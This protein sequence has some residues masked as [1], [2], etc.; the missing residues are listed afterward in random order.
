M[1]EGVIADFSAALVD[2]YDILVSSLPPFF[3]NFVNF[4]VIVFFIFIYSVFVWKF[5]KFISH[6]NIFGLNLN[7]YN[8]TEDPTTNKL[9]GGLFYFLEYLI[10]LPFAIFVW[11]FGVTIFLVVMGKSLD[12]NTALIISAAVVAAIRMTSY[13]NG[14]LSKELAKLLPLNLLA[15][16]LIESGFFDA[17]RILG[18]IAQI[19]GLLSNVTTYLI[20]IIIL[21]AVLR[22]FDFTFS[23]FGLEEEQ[24]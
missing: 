2:S 1:A 16:S 4:F 13:Y 20:F 18:Q 7:K 15:L 5:H 19:Q 12:V 9:V 3:H 11:F 14:N 6:K 23:L 24:E 22:F 17:Q 10:V 8:Q 21:E